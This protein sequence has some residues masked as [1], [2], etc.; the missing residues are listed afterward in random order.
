VNALLAD[1]PFTSVAAALE[2]LEEAVSPLAGI[3]T[4][5]ISATHTTDEASLPNCG[6]QLC[7]ARRTLGAPTVEWGSGAHPDPARARAAAIGE[8][9][10][11]YSAM[12]VPREL[13]QITTARELKGKAV[14]PSRF[15]L[16]H[17]T[18]LAMPRFPCDPFTEDTR[19]AFVEGV[20][21]TDGEPVYLPAELVY[22][23]RPA[24]RLRPIAYS[25]TSGLACAPTPVEAALAAAL[26]LVERDAVMLAWKCRLSL[27]LLDWSNDA[28]LVSLDRRFFCRSRLRF[29]VLDGS[30][31]L[32]VP[33]AIA[34]VHG[35]PGS[36]AALAMGAGSA[37]TIGEAWLKALAEGFGVYRWL[38]TQSADTPA[39]SEPDAVESFDGHMRYFAADERAA[40]AAF[41]DVSEER[42]A[43]QDV[44]PLE[45]GRP[46]QQLDTL[47][48]RLGAHG[49]TAYAVDVTSP[50]VRSLGLAVVRVVVPELCALEASHRARFLGGRRLYTAAY[51]AGLLPAPLDVSELN[52]LPHPFP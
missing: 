27:P 47:L 10:E 25:T 16:F 4:R 43:T 44:R 49:I 24:S 9:L 36:G 31:F 5:T 21:L 39:P 26:E 18:Q 45:G 35:T 8:A 28:G 48:R 51:E 32:D 19:T 17:P 15:A 1:D 7:S 30:R 52:A 34:V 22:L 42:T 38:R 12:F 46:R 37:A 13:V 11:R 14:P 50:D 33:V 20:S 29:A 2:R 6:A 23:A 3:V 40:L 41:L